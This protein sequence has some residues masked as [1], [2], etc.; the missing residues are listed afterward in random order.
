MLL[1]WVKNVE[2][3]FRS[4]N[5]KYPNNPIF[6]GI[7]VAKLVQVSFWTAAHQGLK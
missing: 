3:S 1:I 5:E 7:L 2:V 4:K 6:D